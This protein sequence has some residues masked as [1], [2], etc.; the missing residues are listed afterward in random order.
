[1]DRED[2]RM[3]SAGGGLAAIALGAA[4]VPLREWTSASNLAFVFLLLTILMAELGGPTAA[5]V[6]AIVSAMSLNFFLTVP[7]LTLMIDKPDDVVAFAALLV[8]GLV[9]AAFG[10]SRARS[11]AAARRSR[12]AVETL[13]QI[14]SALQRGMAK[15]D[16][17]RRLR[18]AFELGR[19]V[20]RDGHDRVV[21]ADPPTADAP[22]PAAET[23]AADT[24]LEPDSVPHRWAARGFR[25]PRGG[26]RLRLDTPAGP[27]TLELWEGNPDGLGHDARRALTVAAHLLA[28]DLATRRGG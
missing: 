12:H 14:T 4:L 6:T 22:A 3:W 15:D 24:L 27:V 18:A 1:M 7:Y 17:L 8:C 2:R 26:G 19:I 13:A 5:V 23:L 20:L 16:V 9:A 11:S 10:R 25:L 21:A 28:A